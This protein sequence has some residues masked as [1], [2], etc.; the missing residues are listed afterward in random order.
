MKT[1]L[2]PLAEINR[3]TY[4]PRKPLKPG[5]KEYEALA[6]SLN[7]FGLAAPLV[8]NERT[9]TLISG[10]Q[11][12]TVLEAQGATEVEV[13]LVDMEEE[14][15][16]LLNIALNKIE[17]DW[18]YDKLEE[19]FKE[20]TAD[21]IKFTGFYEEEL[22]SLFGDIHAP[23]FEE[24]EEPEEETA[25]PE[26]EEKTTPESK[27]LPAQFNIFLSF[28]TKELAEEWL[29]GEG[30]NEEFGGARNITIKMEGIGYGK[31]C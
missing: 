30:V 27:K 25:E 16:K 6:N 24:D 3:A 18:E 7:H 20:F 10:H 8:V 29:R 5:D 12:L 11:R 2:I 28:P 31:R 4:N 14:Q 19:L 26:K 21:E 13:V 22:T 9:G 15:E 1:K 17:G 23:S